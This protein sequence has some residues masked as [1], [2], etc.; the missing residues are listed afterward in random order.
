MKKLAALLVLAV[1]LFVTLVMVPQLLHPHP[2][3]PSV[4]VSGAVPVD[5]SDLVGMW[6]PNGAAAWDMARTMPAMAKKLASLAPDGRARLKT[7]F[8]ARVTEASI[9]FTADTM[10]MIKP[11]ARR[12]QRYK[13]S[14]SDGNVF[15]I[16]IIDD[17]GKA[18]QSKPSQSKATVTHDRLELFEAEKP[19]MVLVFNRA[20]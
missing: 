13:I 12:E 20:Y 14:A 6:V 19:D 17:Q 18:S 2:A 3:T 7:L 4:Q 5:A 11:G 1:V 16:D 15:T 10:I 8:L 9:Q